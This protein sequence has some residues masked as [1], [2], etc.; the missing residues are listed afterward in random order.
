MGVIVAPIVEG[1]LEAWKEWCRELMGPRAED[2][3]DF[4]R[5]YGLTRH[6]S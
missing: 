3:K 4:N 6:A 5:R 1:K 2:T